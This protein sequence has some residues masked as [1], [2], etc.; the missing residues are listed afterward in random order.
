MNVY[1]EQITLANLVPAMISSLRGRTVWYFLQGRFLRK[2]PL[3]STFGLR[4]FRQVNVHPADYEG[5]PFEANEFAF[6]AADEMHARILEENRGDIGRWRKSLQTDRLDL[7][8]KKQLAMEAMPLGRSY[9]LLRRLAQ[10]GAPPSELV[11]L[12]KPINRLLAPALT[13]L[14]PDSTINIKGLSRPPWRLINNTLLAVLSSSE[15]FARLAGMF[16]RRNLTLSRVPR[17]CKVVKEL[18]WGLGTGR[19]NDDFIVDG[20]LIAP[21]DVLFYYRND[22]RARMSSPELLDIY[23]ENAKKMGYEC[24]DFERTPIPVPM[25]WRVILPRYVWFPLSILL[26]SLIKQVVHPSAGVLNSTVVAFLTY[27]A[28]WEV[29]L[30]SYTPRLNLSLD[31]P[32]LRHNA[33]TI[34]LNLHGSQNVG[35]Q[36]SDDTTFHDVLLAYVGY[37]VYFAWGSLGEKYWEGNWGI[38]QVVHTGYLWGHHYQDSLANRE[39]SRQTL[40]GTD[41]RHRFV[42]SMLDEKID[43]W[44]VSEEDLCNFYRVATQL[45]ERRPDTVVVVK[46][47]RPAGVRHIPSVMS[48]LAPH[49]D[50]GRLVMWDRSVTDV[51]EVIAISDVVVSMWMGVPYLEAIC[52]GKPGFN[53]APAKNLSSPIYPRAHGKI[54]FDEVDALVEAIDHALEHPEDNPWAEIS[55]LIDDVDP[56]R[57]GKGIE[58]MR[59]YI[60]EMCA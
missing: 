11:V 60:H 53:Y 28:G 12:D 7:Y 1:F 36:W 42:V 51:Q 57:D 9:L 38:D 27:T 47:K 19:R 5:L 21:N 43:D 25:V 33:E 30:A 4:W 17:Q 6:A 18:I 24:V 39:D 13:R 26:S 10:E 23:L 16:W 20:E 58:R 34:A 29:F 45:L 52:C 59:Q 50:S 2:I 32:Y 35:F 3:L 56:Y 54:V 15:Y 48:L 8:I 37:N 55:D 46:P 40:F 49:V 14:Y 31:D 41:Q 44:H 22:S